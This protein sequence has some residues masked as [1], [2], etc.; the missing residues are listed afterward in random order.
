MEQ[1]KNGAKSTEIKPRYDLVP[2]E[3]VRYIAER[4]GLGAEHHGERNFEG[5]VGDPEFIRDRQNHAVEHLLQYVNGR[6]TGP[7]KYGEYDTPIDHLKAA[8]TNL[9]MLAYLEDHRI[10]LDAL[11]DPPATEDA[12][13][14]PRSLLRAL[15]SRAA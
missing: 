11:E 2:P 1:F 5:G 3:A 10:S 12:P 7:D 15:L 13:V 4:L 6:T 8:I 14:E 9:A